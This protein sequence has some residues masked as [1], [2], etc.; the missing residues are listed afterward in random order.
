MPRIYS[1]YT[2][3]E[4]KLLQTESKNLGMSL[5]AFQKYRTL[6]SLSTANT[7]DI[8]DLISKMKEVLENKKAGEVFIVASLLS[9]EW[10]TLT[11]SQ[12]NTLAKTLKKIV[13]E[14]PYRYKINTILPGKINQYIILEGNHEK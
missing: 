7:T 1:N 3:E 14:Q 13:D 8:E 9:E 4:I 10:T 6:L 11:R 2:E 5:S 12:K